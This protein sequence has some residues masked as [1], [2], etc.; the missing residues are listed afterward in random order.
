[1]IARAALVVGAV[2]VAVWFASA[3][4]PVRDERAAIAATQSRPPDFARAQ[5][6]FERAAA[7]SRS[8]D[9]DI[10]L[11]QLDAFR[12]RPEAAARR[13][14]TLVRREPENLTAWLLLA[15]TAESVDPALAAQA[16][17]RARELSPPVPPAR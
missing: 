9:P 14:R 17:A 2:L 7:H 13:L 11:A 5:R 1:V 10:R 3:L 16:R 8:S 6:L 4:R 12:R 15:S